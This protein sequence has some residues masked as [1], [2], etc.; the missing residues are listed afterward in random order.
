MV[1]GNVTASVST[2]VPTVAVGK[3]CRD[4]PHG[5]GGSLELD[6][7]EMLPPKR[8]RANKATGILT[9]QSAPRTRRKRAARIPETNINRKPMKAA[10]VVERLATPNYQGI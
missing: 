5:D 10:R 3:H 2:A 7:H 9:A 6:G 1:P 8:A 4:E